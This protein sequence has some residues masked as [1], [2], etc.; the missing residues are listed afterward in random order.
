M[1]TLKQRIL[2]QAQAEAEEEMTTTNQPDADKS[3]KKR[4]ENCRWWAEYTPPPGCGRVGECRAESPFVTVPSHA[5]CGS[6][7]AKQ[8]KD[9][10][11]PT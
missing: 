3:R 1:S 6:W 7:K 10:D 2:E 8:E 9:N 4:C 5:L 11:N